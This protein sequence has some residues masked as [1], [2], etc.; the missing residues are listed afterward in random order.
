MVITAKLSAVRRLV[1]PT[2]GPSSAARRCSA[3]V[4]EAVDALAAGA[5]DDAAALALHCFMRQR[6]CWMAP[7]PL[8]FS[9]GGR[10]DETWQEIG[11]DTARR[12]FNRVVAACVLVVA[13]IA[14]V[15]P[16]SAQATPPLG[17]EAGSAA[18][19]RQSGNEL[20]TLAGSAKTPAG[21][22]HLA[23][24]ID[25]VV[26]VDAVARFCLG[27]FWRRATAV[28]RQQYEA[29]FGRVLVNSVIA[30]LGNYQGRTA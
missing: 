8:L 12:R 30:R 28:Q 20:A 2:G 26:D 6:S 14:V 16:L 9:H 29:A 13:G 11:V 19:I 24:F 18:F 10:L 5:P 7:C 17:A 1:S 21:R 15:Q 22:H 3:I 23:A 25:R 4:L 27:R